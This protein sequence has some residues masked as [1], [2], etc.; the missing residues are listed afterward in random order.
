[1]KESTALTEE[2]LSPGMS[3]TYG[4]N[5]PDYCGFNQEMPVKKFILYSFCW[6][7]WVGRIGGCTVSLKR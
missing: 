4:S 7:A 6:T 1:M 3:H 5:S 2:E